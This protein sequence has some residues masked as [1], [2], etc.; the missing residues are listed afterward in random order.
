MHAHMSIQ[1]MAATTWD[2]EVAQ[3]IY[4]YT[5]V[6]VRAQ[7]HAY[8]FPYI[9]LEKK[10]IMVCHKQCIL[11]FYIQLKSPFKNDNYNLAIG[12]IAH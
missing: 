5:Y 10:F 3:Y 8:I 7:I 12:F 9:F 4:M 2:T 1:K 11:I 6:C